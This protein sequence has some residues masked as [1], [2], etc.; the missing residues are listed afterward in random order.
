MTLLVQIGPG[1]SLPRDELVRLITDAV[2][3]TP[4][5]FNM[6]S[7]RVV[8]LLGDSHRDFWDLCTASL[9][10]ET[11]HMRPNVAFEHFE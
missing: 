6:Q 4:S 9:P 10:V 1:L 8:I 2:R 7:T 3:H 11:L 5:M